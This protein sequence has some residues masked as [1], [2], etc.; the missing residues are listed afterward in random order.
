MDVRYWF[1]EEPLAVFPWAQEHLGDAEPE[2]LNMPFGEIDFER[3]AALQ[4]DL[5]SGVYSGITAEEYATLSQIAPTV[6]QSADHIDFGQPWDEMTVT[7]GRALGK[8]AEA[9]ALVASVR[10]QFEAIRAAHPDWEDQSVVVGAPRGDG[11]FGFVASEDAR[12]R[13]FTSLGF[14][15]PAEFDEIAGDAYWG[16]VSLERA[17]LLDQSLIVFHQM[18]WVD[19]GRE[20]VKSDPLLSRLSAMQE[21]RILFVEG[22]WDDALQF[23]TV[24]SLPYFLEHV[25]ERIELALDSDPETEA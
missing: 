8:A 13:V 5:I 11:Q 21:G 9:E 17:D 10:D 6:A 14:Q 7:V 12:A 19:G 22:T 24:L 20:A 2:V 16:T 18:A 25:G 4:P 23:G 1:G 3:I 15:V